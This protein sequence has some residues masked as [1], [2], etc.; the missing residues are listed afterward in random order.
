MTVHLFG[1]RSSPSCANYALRTTAVDNENLLGSNTANFIKNNFYVDDGLISVGSSEEAIKLI[2]EA[3]CMCKKGGFNLQKF[4]C[5]KIEVISSIPIEDRASAVETDI[6]PDSITER[7]LGIL[8]SVNDDRFQFKVSLQDR[9]CTRRGILATISSIYDP[10]GFL[11]PYMLT[12]KLILQSL[13]K[14]G[15]DWGHG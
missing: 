3:K 9:P 15:A 2:Q 8:W 13:C 1:A 6:I 10:L 4:L 12:G 11:A 14:E 7:T 5:N